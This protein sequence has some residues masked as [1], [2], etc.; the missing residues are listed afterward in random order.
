[1]TYISITFYLFVTAVL[2]LYYILPLKY[3]W[4][5]LLGGSLLFY[6]E[7]MGTGSGMAVILATTLAAYGAGVL[8]ERVKNRGVLA[9]AVLL[10]VIP[11]FC[12]KN[13]NYVLEVLLHRSSV[14]WIVPLGISF[15]T[16]QVISY[17]ADV[18]RGRV[19]AQK[20]PA[21]FML[22]VMFFPQIVQGPIPRYERLAGQL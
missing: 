5:V 14:E 15:Y 18:Y 22:F 20:N 21:K 2:L 9:A 16:L 11:W 17:L 4:F 3:R 12:V 7:A 8:L 13:G 1:M 10:M 6:W 19:A